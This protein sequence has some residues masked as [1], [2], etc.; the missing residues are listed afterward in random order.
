LT[1]ALALAHA[2]ND[3]AA[4]ARLG[5]LAKGRHAAIARRALVARALEKGR[6]DEAI[7]A[8]G[9]ADDAMFGATDRAVV[10]TLAQADAASLEKW[11][12]PID[13]DPEVELLAAA[14]RAAADA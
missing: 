8:M 13:R 1:A 9:D 3:E 5:Q 11:L 12:A 7:A 14:I 6:G 10:A 2:S 4:A